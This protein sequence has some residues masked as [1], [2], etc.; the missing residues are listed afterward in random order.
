MTSDDL[1]SLFD[2]ESVGQDRYVGHSP[3][4]GWKRV[5][6]GQV[7][8]QALIAAQRTVEGRAPHSLHAYFILGGDPREPIVFEVER[9][10]D[11]RSFATRRVLAR[12][13]GE[14]IFSLSA[15]F[16]VEEQGLEHQFPMPDAP[17]PDGMADPVRLVELAGESAQRQ[18]Q[19]KGFFDR[20]RPIEIRPLDLRRYQPAQPGQTREP[21]QSFW[22]RIAGRLPDDPAIHRAALA[23]LSDMTLLDTVLAAH[24]YSL[25]SGKFQAASLDH[26]IW[27]HRPFR[28]DEWLLY[29]QDSPSACGARG[30]I[31]GL[32]YSRAG[33]LA[34]SVA[35]EGLLRVRRP[36]AAI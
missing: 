3:P 34:A 6:G 16:Q 7:I 27:L 9:I 30:L 28:A 11:G 17:D 36:A 15:S 2:L 13:R 31:R 29:V 19:M 23:Y 32:L 24:G 1:V 33:A 12:Q 4:N 20:I 14:A 26:A 10:R 22:I 35:Q 8:A 5:F 25:S 18:M 21:R